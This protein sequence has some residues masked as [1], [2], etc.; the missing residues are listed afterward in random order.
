MPTTVRT[1]W[2]KLIGSEG[3][4]YASNLVIGSDNS[5]YVSD[6]TNSVLLDGQINNGGKDIYVSKLNSNGSKQWIKLVGTSSDQIAYSSA[7][8]SENNIYILGK[9]EIFPIPIIYKFNSEGEQQWSK[10]YEKLT[11]SKPGGIDI[12]SDGSIYI[13]GSTSYNLDLTPLERT[14]GYREDIFLSKLNS[15]GTEEWS[16]LFGSSTYEA[17]VKSE[18]ADDGSIY[19]FGS[20]N[21]D[22]GGQVY[23]GGIH[24]G[25]ISKFDSDG[26]EKWTKLIG[27]SGREYI[28]D[29]KIDKDGFIYLTGHTDSNLNGVINNGE[30]DAFVSKLNAD[31]TTRWTKLIGSSN[32]DHGSSI[33][34]SSDGAIYITGGTDG[35]LDG[36]GNKGYRDVFVSKLDSIGRTKWTRLFGTSLFDNSGEI[37]L[38]NNSITIS[39]TTLGNL[40]DET[41]GGNY[42]SFI[43]NLKE[44]TTNN[45]S[46]TTRDDTLLNT[47]N[48]DIIDGNSGIDTVI[49]SGKFLD[50]SFS[51][52]TDSIDISDKRTGSNDGTDTLKNIEYIQFSDQ[53]VKESNVDYVST[54]SGEFSDYKF[55]NKGN[56]I[57]QIKTDDGYDTITGLP[58]LIFSGESATS[59]F[60]N[61]S[62]IVDVKGTFDQVTGLNTDSGQMFRLYNASF[63]RLPD[64]DGLKYWIGKYTSGENDSR[65]V[66]SSFL[67]SAEFKQRYGENVSDSTYVNTLYKNVLGREA[68]QGGLDY[69]VGQL[70]S[71]AE[72]RYEVLLGFS[73]SAENKALFSEM[74]G[75]V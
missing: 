52:E 12:G 47:I 56:G 63:K 66:A 74:T 53:T 46:G 4:E 1:N 39:G 8:D 51:R 58:S 45:I 6:Y 27:S 59:S 54:Y 57:Y 11:W 65:A 19:I 41:N 28:A 70:N 75:F 33:D 42:D 9:S 31:G 44:V 68:D 64:P 73:E 48:D 34:I 55:Y 14:S 3:A 71:G 5:I 18:I 10:S 61:I 37:I 22:L 67:A 24:D 29:T 23:N 36:Q 2:T 35:D 21:G 15:D 40:N 7:I 72:T 32:S 62:A 60:R 20:T 49:Y 43:L 30:T 38:N 16:K 69:W 25:F 50:Y 17:H 26:T 13:T